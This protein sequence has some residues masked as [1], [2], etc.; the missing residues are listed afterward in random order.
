MLLTM[1]MQQDA[2]GSGDLM[3]GPS[4]TPRVVPSFQLEKEKCS[5]LQ[6]T[7]SQE[8]AEGELWRH[9]FSGWKL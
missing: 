1:L 8:L 4:R 6:T 7:I 5:L 2:G 9:H 3:Q